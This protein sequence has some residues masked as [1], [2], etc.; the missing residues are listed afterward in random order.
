P[1]S[2]TVPSCTITLTSDGLVHGS[3]LSCVST[4]SRICE[5]LTSAAT[6]TCLLRLAKACNR[7]ARLTIPTTLPPSTIGTRLIAFFSSRF[8]ILD[9]G[10]RGPQLLHDGSSRP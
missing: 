5:S 1:H 2:S 6:S 8:A 4:L 7:F 9:R 10:Y 3:A